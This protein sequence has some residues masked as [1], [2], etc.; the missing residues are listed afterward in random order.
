MIVSMLRINTL[1]IVKEV[2]WRN[3]VC[4]HDHTGLCVR[5]LPKKYVGYLSECPLSSHVKAF[6]LRT[7]MAL[8][9]K[10]GR[11]SKSLKTSFAKNS[12]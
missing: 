9:D 10:S 8:Y 7:Q 2:P 3:Q 4:L 1:G 11:H 5:V 12:C 6:I